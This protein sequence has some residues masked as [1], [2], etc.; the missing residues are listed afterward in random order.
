MMIDASHDYL[1]KERGELSSKNKGTLKRILLSILVQG[2]FNETT[3][4]FQSLADSALAQK[5]TEIFHLL[6]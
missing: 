6:K 3:C 4:S 5:A 2:F 1:R